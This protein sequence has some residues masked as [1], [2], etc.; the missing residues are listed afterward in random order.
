MLSESFMTTVFIV[1]LYSSSWWIDQYRD[2]VDSVFISLLH[3]M[4]FLNETSQPPTLWA[5]CVCV[6]CVC[7]HDWEGRK[8]GE[9]E[10]KAEI[11]FWPENVRLGLWFRFLAELFELGQVGQEPE[12][13]S[14]G[15]IWRLMRCQ[16]YPGC[17][18]DF[19]SG[20]VVFVLHCLQLC[21]KV[22]VHIHPHIWYVMCRPPKQSYSLLFVWWS[23]SDQ[24]LCYTAESLTLFRGNDSLYLSQV[25][26]N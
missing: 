5:I 8:E 15:D 23:L 12:Q 25:S 21:W 13:D 14:H 1:W 24:L 11:E 19:V 6:I 9:I 17:V 4:H 18:L 10:R 22:G 16:R 2:G 26:V 7:V 3:W 20:N